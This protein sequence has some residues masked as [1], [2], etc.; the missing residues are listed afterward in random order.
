M[1]LTQDECARYARHLVIPELGEEGQEKLAAAS[2]LVVGAGGLGSPCL[3]Y[4]AAAGVGRL[5]VL[6]DD[7]VEISNLQRQILHSSAD[8]GRPKA[9]SAAEKLR[10]LN[11][12]IEVVEHRRRFGADNA[13]ELVRAHDVVVTAVDSLPARF[14][15]NDACVLAG[16][17]LVEAAIL[18]FVGLALTIHGGRSSCYR[19]L[20]PSLPAGG[21]VP[22]PAEAGVFG[23][24]AG[25]MGCIQANE[26][27]KVLTGI[28]RPLYDRLLQFDALEMTFDEVAVQRDPGCPVCGERPMIV[29]I[30]SSAADLGLA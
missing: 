5:G 8:L 11:P 18:R 7:V 10:A 16:K 4:L 17:I 12:C 2:V 9:A 23:P 26:V 27:I 30:A 6:D 24:V 21:A 20:F 22:A 28:G 15:L 14:L 1:V 25:V 3:Y 19:C 29:D 13:A